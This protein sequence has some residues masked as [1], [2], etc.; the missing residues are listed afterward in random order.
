MAFDAEFY[1]QRLAGLRVTAAQIKPA[2]EVPGG[3]ARPAWLSVKTD[4]RREHGNRRVG[5][6]FIA[7]PISHVDELNALCQLAA[8]IFEDAAL[9]AQ[10]LRNA[11]EERDAARRAQARAER[12]LAEVLTGAR[13]ASTSPRARSAG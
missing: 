2:E 7:E 13:R 10:Y 1:A 3:P 8:L 5:W 6:T 9:V 12:R 11:F 4:I